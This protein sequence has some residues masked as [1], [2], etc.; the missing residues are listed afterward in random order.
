MS[1]FLKYMLRLALCGNFGELSTH[2]LC[3]L[4]I[5]KVRR[6]HHYTV[7]LQMY[8]WFR[9]LAL[10]SPLIPQGSAKIVC[11]SAG[12]KS[13]MKITVS[14][15]RNKYDT[16]GWKWCTIDPINALTHDESEEWF[17]M[18]QLVFVLLKVRYKI[19]LWLWRNILRRLLNHQMVIKFHPLNRTWV[20]LKS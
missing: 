3:P 10:S 19:V 5:C 2:C 8:G 6:R 13:N 16:G 17:V 14:K 15:Q 7:T 9:H 11:T 12:G 20:M 1:Y 18:V 4:H